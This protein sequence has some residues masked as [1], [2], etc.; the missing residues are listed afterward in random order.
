MVRLYLLRGEDACADR[1]NV[2]L[3]PVRVTIFQEH[4]D[5][6]EY[7]EAKF[8]DF[9]VRSSHCDFGSRGMRS[10][11]EPAVAPPTSSK[12]GNGLKSGIA[13]Y[14]SSKSTTAS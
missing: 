3:I 5:R 1:D 6:E 8:E 9:E 2:L 10:H 7:I 14:L 12:E 11:F 4:E 13:E